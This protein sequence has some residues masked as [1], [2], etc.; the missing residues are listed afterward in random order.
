ME[1][2]NKFATAE[3]RKKEDEEEE[4]GWRNG[5]NFAVSSRRQTKR[6]REGW[7]RLLKKNDCIP[8]FFLLSSLFI[9]SIVMFQI[10]ACSFFRKC[11][12]LMH[13]K[14]PFSKHNRISPQKFSGSASSS[15]TQSNTL[16]CITL[17]TLPL[18]RSCYQFFFSHFIS[19]SVFFF[20]FF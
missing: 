5:Q 12:A 15:V 19:C 8:L 11:V 7:V 16:L 18:K 13:F 6:S 4:G 14:S 20:F 1:P 17:Q 2:E 10:H 9:P 3:E